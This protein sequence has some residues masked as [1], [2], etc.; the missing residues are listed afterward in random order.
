VDAFRFLNIGFAELKGHFG[1]HAW[2]EEI[3]SIRMLTLSYKTNYLVILAH[4]FEV[5]NSLFD[6][7]FTKIYF[8]KNIIFGIMA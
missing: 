6:Y 2:F 5:C 1:L 4:F 8:V 7:F 3:L